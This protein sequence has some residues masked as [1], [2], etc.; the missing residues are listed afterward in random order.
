MHLGPG[1]FHR[2]HQ[3]YY[4]DRL[5]EHDPRWA[6]SAVSLYSLGVRDAL[7]PQDGLYAL[8]E[9]D[10]PAKWRVI[11]AIREVLVAPQTPDRVLARLAHPDTRLVTLTI[12]EKGYTLDSA[13]RLD[14]ND[15][16]IAADLTGSAPPRTAV[17]WIAA[18]LAARRAARSPTL[19]DGELRQPLR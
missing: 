13:G 6:I 2:A 8:A 7:A 18:G 12:T 15:T 5:L 11:G 9:L 3:A 14:L 16:G 17:G 1:A 4:F 10:E 19:H